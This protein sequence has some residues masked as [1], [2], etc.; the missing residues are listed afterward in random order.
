MDKNAPAS[1]SQRFAIFHAC[2][3]LAS[4]RFLG[5]WE[6]PITRGEISPLIKVLHKKSTSTDAE[7]LAA[8]DKLAGMGI[9]YEDAFKHKKTPNSNNPTEAAP[10]KKIDIIEDTIEVWTN[11]EDKAPK[12]KKG[13]NQGLAYG[14]YCKKAKKGGVEPLSFDSWK[15]GTAKIW[16]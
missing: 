11:E 10:L 15:A 7:K 5:I 14:R 6:F 12:A 1:K 13:N 4:I 16:F 2:R 8:M 9:T 3:D